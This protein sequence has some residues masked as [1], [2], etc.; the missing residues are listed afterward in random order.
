MEQTLHCGDP[1]LDCAAIIF[2]RAV[3]ATRVVLIM[4]SLCHLIERV[5]PTANPIEPMHV[6]PEMGSRSLGPPTRLQGGIRLS[7]QSDLK[8][9]AC[10]VRAYAQ[11][12]GHP[13]VAGQ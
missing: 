11:D 3:V 10:D 9:G 13:E 6:V 5:A 12:V 7:G 4:I 2:G 1:L 8:G